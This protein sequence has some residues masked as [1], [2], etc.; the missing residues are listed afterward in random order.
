MFELADGLPDT[1]DGAECAEIDPPLADDRD[2]RLK[3]VN[4]SDATET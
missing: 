1:A 4:V 2:G 3:R